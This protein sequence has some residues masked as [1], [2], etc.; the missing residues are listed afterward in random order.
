MQRR[1]RG[2]LL[3]WAGLAL[4]GAAFGADAPL[5]AP[6]PPPAGWA[7]G[8]ATVGDALRA[9]DAQ[10]PAGVLLCLPEGLEAKALPAGAAAPALRDL[11]NALAAA[12]GTTWSAEQGTILFARPPELDPIPG[13]LHSG[14][15]R[16]LDDVER[17]LAIFAALDE[18]CR[19]ALREKGLVPF[20]AL[21]AP[22]AALLRA[23]KSGRAMPD[24]GGVPLMELP[25]DQFYFTGGF[26]V[27]ARV[28]IPG[29]P[30]EVLTFYRDRISG[31][32]ADLM[33]PLREL[34]RAGVANP[35]AAPA[36]AKP[37][38][39]PAEAAPAK[40]DPPPADDL[41]A[42]A[43][44]GD[45]AVRLPERRPPIF[46]LGE[47]ITALRTAGCKDVYADARLAG[48][49]LWLGCAR[50]PMPASRLARALRA[51]TGWHWRRA[52][53]AFLLARFPN[54]YWFYPPPER[55]IELV[56]E[57]E[58]RVR[59]RMLPAAAALWPPDLPPPPETAVRYD[60]PATPWKDVPEAWQQ[61]I[62]KGLRSV[63]DSPS[64]GGPTDPAFQQKAREQ[65]TAQSSRLALL[66]LAPR[67]M[68]KATVRFSLGVAA[69]AAH[70]TAG[71]WGIATEG[72][73]VERKRE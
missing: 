29:G 68:D 35:P 44:P 38:A 18:P 6:V 11:L 25:A 20:A 12:S 16:N 73:S 9:V 4:A 65:A 37:P 67:G 39:S 14:Y 19:Q 5:D 62:R 8:K 52:G 30:D 71:T 47:A 31:L 50:A 59:A 49:R 64:W 56:I 10:A 17:A 42:A 28:A 26:W 53:G 36:A 22:A 45:P 21:P 2:R 51:A 7:E 1:V 48:T 69:L 32:A 70:P 58:N 60:A 3:W 15:Y 34:R 63:A 40:E 23:H 61:L 13:R 55:Q 72:V 43:M 27:S 41:P 57:A 54:G 46:T 33:A 24:V 66:L